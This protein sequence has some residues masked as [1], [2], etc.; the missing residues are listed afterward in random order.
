MLA[1]NTWLGRRNCFRRGEQESRFHPRMAVWGSELSSTL[2]D[3]MN[4]FLTMVS[5]FY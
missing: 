1:M 4:S 5:F 2:S 3:Q